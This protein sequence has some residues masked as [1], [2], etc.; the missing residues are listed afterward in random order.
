MV[1]RTIRSV[2]DGLIVED[3]GLAVIFVLE[4][5]VAHLAPFN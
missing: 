4:V 3:E 1:G 2:N 5:L